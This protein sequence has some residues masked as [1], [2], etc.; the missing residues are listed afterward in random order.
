MSDC[1]TP[2]AHLERPMSD[3]SISFPLWMIAWFLLGQAAPLL[4]IATAGLA[5]ALVLGRSSDRVGRRRWLKLS[6]AIVGG[7]WLGR[8]QLLGGR[9]RR[10]DQER[11][12][13]GV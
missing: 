7:A 10:S 4:T 5:V 2:S 1:E 13:S 12:L 3:I 6:L 9:S 8:D 11:Y